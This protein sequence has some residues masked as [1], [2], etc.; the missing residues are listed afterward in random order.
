MIGYAYLDIDGILYYKSAEYID[1]ENPNFW[2]ENGE[3]VVEKWKFNTDNRAT[4][5]AMF[6]AFQ[7]LMLK[8]LVVQSLLQTIN[9]RP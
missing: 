8:D 7:R 6:V 5:V 4:M 3:V 1:T 9:Y 2:F